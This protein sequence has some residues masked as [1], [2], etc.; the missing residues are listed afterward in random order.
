[1]ARIRRFDRIGSTQ[2]VSYTR[3]LVDVKRERWIADRFYRLM[4]RQA[5]FWSN[6][7]EELGAGIYRGGN[8][9]DLTQ[10]SERIACLDMAPKQYIR[11]A[12]ILERLARREEEAQHFETSCDYYFRTCLFYAS[13]TWGIFDSDNEELVW[14]TEKVRTMFDK[15]I[16]YSKNRMERVEVPFEGRSLS[17]ILTLNRTGEEAPTIIL[18]PGMDSQKET[19]TNHLNNPF[20]SRGMNTLAL[21]GPGQGESLPRKIWVDADNHARAGKAAIDY[22]SKRPE[23]D[24]NKIGMFGVS[25]GTYWTPLIAIHDNRIKALATAASCYYTKDHIFNETSPNFKLRFM[26]MAGNLDDEGVDKLAAKMT[27]EGQESKITCPHI[28]F[29]GEFDHLTSTEEAFR[30]FDR[31]GS[32]IKELRIY[33]NQYHSMARFTDEVQTMAADWLRDRLNDVPVKQKRKIVYVDSNKQEHSVD[34]RAILS[35]FSDI[36]A[37]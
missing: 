28:I 14:L 7:R 5:F 2:E 34:E 29:H 18:V 17:G 12:K 26:W 24:A 22:L 10:T 19:L 33:E 21:D 6:P 37:E 27:L 15:V 31:L 20:V 25:M 1:M 16:K 11:T 23:V 4:G 9:F 8:Y 13:A 30:Y 35:G 3:T 36:R 32:E